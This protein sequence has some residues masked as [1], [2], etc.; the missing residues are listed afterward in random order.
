MVKVRVVCFFVKVVIIDVVEVAG[1][2]DVVLAFLVVEVVDDGLAVVEEVGLAVEGDD[3]VV[4]FVVV[5]KVVGFFVVVVCFVVKVVGFFVVVVCFV[6]VAVGL[7]VCG[8]VVVWAS[9]YTA[10]KS[11]SNN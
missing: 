11:N 10:H 6:V 8:F 2:T 9:C 5:L 3:F 4:A 1:L 7:L